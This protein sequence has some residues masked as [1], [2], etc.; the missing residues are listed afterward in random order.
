M[1]L[2]THSPTVQSDTPVKDLY[3]MGEIPPM[4]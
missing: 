4:G 1:A 3:A 2:D